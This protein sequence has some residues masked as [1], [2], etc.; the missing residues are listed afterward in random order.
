MARTEKKISQL[1]RQNSLLHN[2]AMVG[3]LYLKICICMIILAFLAR[4][5]IPSKSKA[6]VA[7]AGARNDSHL[8]TLPN[9]YTRIF[10]KLSYAYVWGSPVLYMKKQ[11]IETICSCLQNHIFGYIT[12]WRKLS[13]LLISILSSLYK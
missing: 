5:I 9:S 8:A 3:L 7:H 6:G 10:L 12:T 11:Q 4:Y 2:F 1:A 13:V